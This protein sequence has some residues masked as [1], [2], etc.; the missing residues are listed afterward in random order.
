MIFFWRISSNF[1]DYPK[2]LTLTESKFFPKQC[3][4]FQFLFFEFRKFQECHPKELST[5]L[6]LRNVYYN[7][8]HLFDRKKK[9]EAQVEEEENAC[10]LEL[11]SMTAK[12]KSSKKKAINPGNELN[13]CFYICKPQKR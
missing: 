12:K 6:S 1:T 11:W 2:T 3:L 5:F 4:I 9:E 7:S 13:S 8:L 10:A